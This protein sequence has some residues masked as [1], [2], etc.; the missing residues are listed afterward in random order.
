MRHLTI[1]SSPQVARR[2]GDIS[3][4]GTAEQT[5][6]NSSSSIKPL[7]LLIEESREVAQLLVASLKKRFQVAFA[8]NRQQGIEQAFRLMPDLIIIDGRKPHPDHFAGCNTFKN[9][10]RTCFIP[11]ILLIANANAA[12]RL[13]GLEAG[14]DA[15]LADPFCPEELALQVLNLLDLRRKLQAHALE[16]CEGRTGSFPDAASP[17]NAFLQTVRSAVEA[18]LDDHCFH[19]SQLAHAV[20]M[21][22][23]RLY[24]KLKALTGRSPLHFIQSVRL[25]KAKEM[26]CHSDLNV[27]EIAYQT[28]FGSPAHFTHLFVREQGVCPTAFRTSFANHHSA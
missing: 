23:S 17:M 7:V 8:F 3:E 11:L 4:N 14:A 24:R 26:L 16:V 21:S 28:G 10:K 19:A 2:V 18:G 6:S 27:S 15:C 12:A 22:Q 20:N 9:D 1:T 25:Q 5:F 13:Q